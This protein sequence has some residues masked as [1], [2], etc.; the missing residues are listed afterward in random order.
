MKTPI[1]VNLA[2]INE[3]SDP[4][5]VKENAIQEHARHTQEMHEHYTI[6]RRELLMRYNNDTGA[7]CENS[8]KLFSAGC[9]RDLCKLVTSQQ[10]KP[11]G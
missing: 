7:S 9:A 8:T 1:V 5:K 4:Q 3:V 10:G 11:I 2:G 6:V